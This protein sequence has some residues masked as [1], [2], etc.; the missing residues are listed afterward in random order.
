MFVNTKYIVRY[1]SFL[2]NTLFCS[3]LNGAAFCEVCGETV[4]FSLNSGK[5]YLKTW[6]YSLKIRRLQ[7]DTGR[8]DDAQKRAGAYF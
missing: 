1:T 7:Y 8:D 4:V 3:F 5:I 6:R 2:V